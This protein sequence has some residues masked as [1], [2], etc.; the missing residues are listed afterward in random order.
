M[1]IAFLIAVK[2]SEQI[3]GNT[4]I[5]S[6]IG[7]YD[8]VFL[9]KHWNHVKLSTKKSMKLL[10]KCTVSTIVS[11]IFSPNRKK[12]RCLNVSVLG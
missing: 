12:D 1:S 5:F 4:Q 8:S 10:M 2:L 3:Q 7:F 11:Y 6:Y 9:S